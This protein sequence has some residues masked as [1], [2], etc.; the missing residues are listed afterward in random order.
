MRLSFL[1][2]AHGLTGVGRLNRLIDGSRPETS[3]EHSWHLALTAY[4]L[5][6]YA[7]S[8]VQIERVIEMLV[9]HD[10]VEVEAGDVPI[11]DE[12]ARAAVV[13]AEEQA[14]HKL[15]GMLPEPDAA[16][17]L[18]MWHEFEAG[19]TADAR[20]ARALDRVQPILLHWSGGGAVWQERGVS[21]L[22]ER[23]LIEV[24]EQFWPPLAPLA[25]ALIDDA[26]AGGVLT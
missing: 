16:T 4:V 19:E 14:A 6:D 8:E 13:D 3:A 24:I 25:T 10:V 9:I 23:R 1:M 2:I 15:F 5:R 17:Y 12:A 21:E 26:V 18:A 7:G 20:F 11:Y 22:Q